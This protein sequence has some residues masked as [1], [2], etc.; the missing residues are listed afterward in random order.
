MEGQGNQKSPI[1]TWKGLL[2]KE[3]GEVGQ[4]KQTNQIIV[5]L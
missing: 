4:F 1:V 5:P 2:E 3:G